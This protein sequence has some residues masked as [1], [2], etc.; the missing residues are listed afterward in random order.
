L[1]VK[2]PVA[3]FLLLV[4]VITGCSLKDMITP[5]GTPLPL[6]TAT[7]NEEERL[8]LLRRFIAQQVAPQIAGRQTLV[9]AESIVVDPANL[10]GGISADLNQI[11]QCWLYQDGNLSDC[12]KAVFE[13]TFY[14]KPGNPP[15]PKVIFAIIQVNNNEATLILENFHYLQEAHPMDGY[16]IVLIYDNGAWQE[17]SRQT[18]N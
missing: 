9:V 7:L 12:S 16:R 3:L 14:D 17:S 11:R 5:T 13:G 4:L 2:K 6:P 8:V 18:Q 10:Q 1:I 15:V